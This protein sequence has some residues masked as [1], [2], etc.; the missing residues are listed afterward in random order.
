MKTIKMIVCA[1]ADGTKIQYEEEFA[2]GALEHYFEQLYAKAQIQASL[3]G[4]YGPRK[5]NCEISSPND[6]YRNEVIISVYIQDY[7]GGSVFVQF[8]DHLDKDV[9][10]MNKNEIHKNIGDIHTGEKRPY[11]GFLASE[12]INDD[13]RAVVNAARELTE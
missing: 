6:V 5:I 1:E 12:L 2:I 9:I 8:R 13:V 10:D 4:C 7:Y 11:K 3:H